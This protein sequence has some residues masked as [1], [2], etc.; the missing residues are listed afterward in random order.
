MAEVA[1]AAP[2]QT[3]RISLKIALAG[4]VLT[5]LGMIVTAIITT[6]TNI[7]WLAW[8]FYP[9]AATGVLAGGLVMLIGSIGAPERK[10]W[11]GMTLIAWSL[12]TVVSPLAGIYWY[13]VPWGILAITTPLVIWIFVTLFRK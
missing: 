4:F 11:R 8:A 5:C 1:A 3:K 9:G 13:L 10:S 2:A 7:A 6:R 12:L